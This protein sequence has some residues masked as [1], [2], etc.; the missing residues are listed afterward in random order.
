MHAGSDGDRERRVCDA[1]Q[2]AGVGAELAGGDGAVEVVGGVEVDA[3]R[4]VNG[5]AGGTRAG[6]EAAG[7]GDTAERSAGLVE[8]EGADR[9]A[10]VVGGVEVL[11]A[12][13]DDHRD[14]EEAGAVGARDQRG[15][16]AGDLIVDGVAV[17]L[18]GGLVGHVDVTAGGVSDD[19]AGC[20]AGRVTLPGLELAVERGAG[21]R[22]ER[23]GGGVLRVAKDG[24]VGRGLLVDDVDEDVLL[25]G[26]A[27]SR[28][29]SVRR[30]D[31]GG[32]A[33]SR[34]HR[35]GDWVIAD[36]EERL[37]V[38]ADRG[39][40]CSITGDGE[41]RDAAGTRGDRREA[42]LIGEGD[43]EEL[44]GGVDRH[45]GRV[46]SASEGVG[47]LAVEL[48]VGA[49]SEDLDSG[50]FGPGEDEEVL[51]VGRGDERGLALEAGLEGRA[52]DLGQDAGL[53]VHGEGVDV[54]TGGRDGVHVIR[55][56]VA[57]AGRCP[58]PNGYR[59]T[60]RH[61]SLE[62]SFVR[63]LLPFLYVMCFACA[64]ALDGA[65]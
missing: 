24:G 47:L 61:R 51:A 60:C 7:S 31:R 26:A 58:Q 33:D 57:A 43:V 5:D 37:A 65:V 56:V 62:H 14:R 23:A 48:A 42:G 39:A 13:I 40:E 49:D 17:D 12:R 30:D 27:G 64:G 55:Y 2:R 35:D 9:T 44:A 20:N 19:G 1:C 8:G 11:A 45:G 25:A 4:R 59:N 41:D 29:G 46:G 38:D 6:G 22:G 3:E 52:G 16:I 63:H 18:V 34:R 54:R 15:E 28:A 53:V 21:E 32:R 10:V 36:G 50:V